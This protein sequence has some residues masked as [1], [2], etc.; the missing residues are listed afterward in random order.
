MQS[1]VFCAF[2][3]PLTLQIFPGKSEEA[4]HVGVVMRRGLAAMSFL[5]SLVIFLVREESYRV[6]KRFSFGCV[7]DFDAISL[8]LIANIISKAAV[9]PLPA[10]GAYSFLAIFAMYMTT[11][12]HE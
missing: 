7:I 12:R 6:A 3:T 10:I 2:A 5:A 4:A 11:R 9:V 1:S 8:S